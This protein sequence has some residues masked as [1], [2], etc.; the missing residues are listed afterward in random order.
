MGETVEKVCFRATESI[1]RLIGISDGRQANTAINKDR[2]Q[3]PLKVWSECVRCSKNQACDEIAMVRVIEG[4]EELEAPKPQPP[5]DDRYVVP[6]V[7]K[8]GQPARRQK[9]DESQ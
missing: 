2:Q 5:R 8:V 6:V 4:V 9:M 7:L 3:F 1:N